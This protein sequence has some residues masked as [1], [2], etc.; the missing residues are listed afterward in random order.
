MISG[1]R[2]VVVDMGFIGSEVAASLRQHGLDVVTIEPEKTP[3]SRVLGKTSDNAW[4]TFTVLTA[5]G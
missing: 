3:L 1:R 2:V 4:R 5:F